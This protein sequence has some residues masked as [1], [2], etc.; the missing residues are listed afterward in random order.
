MDKKIA[1]LLGGVSALAITPALASPTP[2]ATIETAMHASRYA[3]LL[4]P[5]PGALELL[6]SQPAPVEEAQYYPPPQQAYGGDRQGYGGDQAHHHHHHNDRGYNNGYN[7]GVIPL[8]VPGVAVQTNHHH[9]HHHH[10]QTR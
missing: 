6:A 8:P 4:A 2:P 7:N 9:H 1:G 3:D 5:I 10:H